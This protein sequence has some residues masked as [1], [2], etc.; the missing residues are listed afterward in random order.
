MKINVEALNKAMT[1]SGRR[2][3][4]PQHYAKAS[5]LEWYAA[6]RE[7]RSY[8]EAHFLEKLGNGT[9]RVLE[10]DVDD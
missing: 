9:F 2:V 1:L 5:G 3:I 7:L 10:F 6:R 4:A 8:A